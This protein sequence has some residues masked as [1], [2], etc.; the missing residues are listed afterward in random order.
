MGDVVGRFN[1]VGSVKCLRRLSEIDT[2]MEKYIIC[3]IRCW[4]TP[5][6]TEHED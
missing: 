2:S 3:E 4:D 1:E 6:K 5:N